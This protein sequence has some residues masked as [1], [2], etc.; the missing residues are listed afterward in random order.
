MHRYDVLQEIN[1]TLEGSFSFSSIYD[2][3][4]ESSLDDSEELL[5]GVGSI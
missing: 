5:N 3:S 1:S 4:S 2:S